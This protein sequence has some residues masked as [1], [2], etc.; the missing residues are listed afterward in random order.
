MFIPVPYLDF[1]HIPDPGSRGKKVTGSRIRM[2]NTADPD[3][4]FHFDAYREPDP[5]LTPSF[6][7]AGKSEKFLDLNKY[8][9]A[10]HLVEI[11]TDPDLPK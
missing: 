5:Y 7:Q 4:T 1:I 9:L 8:S 6:M 10:L 3:P 11:K 2:Y